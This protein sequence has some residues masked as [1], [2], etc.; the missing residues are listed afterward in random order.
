MNIKKALL[1]TRDRIENMEKF[2]PSNPSE[3]FIAEE[4]IEYLKFVE[5]ILKKESVSEQKNEIF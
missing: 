5:K 1:I 4:T 3:A 2:T